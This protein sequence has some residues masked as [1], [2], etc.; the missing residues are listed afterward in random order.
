MGYGGIGKP[1]WFGL[2]APAHTPVE[3][4]RRLN[5]A[6][7]AVMKQP[8]VVARLAQWGA[9]PT[10][11]TPEAFALEMHT[12]REAFRNVIAARGIEPE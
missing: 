11:G 6:V 8:E 1:A 5:D 9:E 2:V 4:T 12:T 7:H 10:V 3:A